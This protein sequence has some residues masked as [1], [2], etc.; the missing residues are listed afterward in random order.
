MQTHRGYARIPKTK[1]EFGTHIAQKLNQVWTW[2]I[3]CLLT[4][5]VDLYFKLYMIVD[6]FSR[7]IVGWEVWEVWET[8]TGDYESI[9][10]GN[11]STLNF[12]AIL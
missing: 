3:T 8:E 5:V 6:I 2:D 9:T 11:L 7:E 4:V 1:K 12:L 10:V